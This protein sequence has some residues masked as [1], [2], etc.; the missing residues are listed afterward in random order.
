MRI[1]YEFITFWNFPYFHIFSCFNFHNFRKINF[2]KFLLYVTSLPLLLFELLAQ[3]WD[4]LQFKIDHFIVYIKI[5]RWVI[6]DRISSLA[7]W[8]LLIDTISLLPV[9]YFHRVEPLNPP[10]HHSHKKIEVIIPLQIL[11]VFPAHR[12]HQ[13]YLLITN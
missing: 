9:W 12:D 2:Y 10:S 11:H 4:E 8:Y 3:N 6:D 7:S 5:S 1:P 13:I